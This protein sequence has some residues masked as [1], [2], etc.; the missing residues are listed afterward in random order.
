MR[1]TG[2]QYQHPTIADC[3][4]A[5]RRHARP[6]STA[7]E[8][9]SLGTLLRIP[10][11]MASLNGGL[12]RNQQCIVDSLAMPSVCAFTTS[13]PLL[14]D[15]TNRHAGPGCRPADRHML[16]RWQSVAA[17]DDLV[18]S[19]VSLL[20]RHDALNNTWIIVT[21]VRSS[22]TPEHKPTY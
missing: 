7:S 21:S 18:E 20:E 8:R 1:H 10:P 2:R 14:P 19:V 13:R 11:W 17:V 22:D 12:V 9:T 4:Q 5:S 16:D 6:T 15:V 3:S